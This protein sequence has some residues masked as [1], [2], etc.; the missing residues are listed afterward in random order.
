MTK[1]LLFWRGGTLFFIKMFKMLP[2]RQNCKKKLI[3]IKITKNLIF[4]VETI[5]FFIRIAKKLVFYQY[6]QKV[7]LLL[8]FFLLKFQQKNCVFLK[9]IRK[10]HFF[11]QNCEQGLLFC[12]NCKIGSSFVKMIKT[13]YFIELK[14]L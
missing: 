9:I 1:F 12:K 4:V 8:F 5:Q 3:F 2:V 6:L 7:L 11:L 13:G 14:F 10:S